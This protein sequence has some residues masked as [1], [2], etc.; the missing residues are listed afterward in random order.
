MPTGEFRKMYEAENSYFWFVCKRKLVSRLV[1]RVTLP[2]KALLLDLGCG[3]GATLKTLR[4]VG[5]AVG[6]DCFRE[7]LRYCA[8]RSLRLLVLSSG[9]RL[10]FRD[11][12]FALATSLDSIEHTLDPPSVIRE[13]HRTL[14]PSGWFLLT[15]PAHPA[16]F[17][18]HDYALGHRVRYTK[19][20]LLPLLREGGFEIVMSGHFFSLV[21]PLA[22]GLK[23]YQKWFGSRTRTI[24]Y[25]LPRPLN[26]VL[27]A[28]CSFEAWLFPFLRLPFG[29][30]LVALCRKTP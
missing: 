23:I 7:A 14:A 27:V 19:R 12:C 9:E 6:L 29:T 13:V 8:Q 11:G 4:A 25:S 22:A 15:A 10:P 30:T 3:T 2:E 5:F 24:S 28:I 18:A 26:Q 20:T 17:G 1:G 16:L 21:F